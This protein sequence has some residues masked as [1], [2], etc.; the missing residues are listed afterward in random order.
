MPSYVASVFSS[1]TMF[2]AATR[3]PGRSTIALGLQGFAS[4]WS[5][6]RL[7]ELSLLQM[8]ALMFAVGAACTWNKTQLAWTSLDLAGRTA[9]PTDRHTD[10]RHYSVQVPV[11][12]MPFLGLASRPSSSCLH[13]TVRH[14]FSALQSRWMNLRQ[15]MLC[16]V[17]HLLLRAA[18]AAANLQA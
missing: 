11:V 3:R 15:H 8:F 13:S 14:T 5:C 4:V 10:G 1:N 7:R 16:L 12:T 18:D 2:I 9:C 17:L 6:I